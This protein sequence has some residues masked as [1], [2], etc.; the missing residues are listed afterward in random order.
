MGIHIPVRRSLFSES[1]A[2]G[3]CYSFSITCLVTHDTLQWRH[4]DRDG[5][6]SHQP[7][8]RLLNRL[9]RH[10]WKKTSKLRV[11]G[12]CA[13]NSPVTGEFPAQRAS[14]SEN[15]SFDDVI[16]KRAAHWQPQDRSNSPGIPQPQHPPVWLHYSNLQLYCVDW[17]LCCPTP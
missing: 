11:T 15:V 17:Q 9:F 12:I 13:G 8:D 7:H 2:R 1:G 10:S 3:L 5:D 6:S 4:N 14:N 16:M